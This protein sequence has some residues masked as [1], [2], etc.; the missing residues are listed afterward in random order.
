MIEIRTGFGFVHGKGRIS[1]AMK[2]VRL[3]LFCCFMNSANRLPMAVGL[4]GLV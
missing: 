2:A 3:L 1:L 4:V